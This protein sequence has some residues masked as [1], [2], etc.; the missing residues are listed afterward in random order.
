MI[1]K[2]SY[3]RVAR[4]E[5]YIDYRYTNDVAVKVIPK[6]DITEEIEV[7]MCVDREKK[8]AA[9]MAKEDPYGKL[10]KFLCRTEMVFSDVRNF[11]VVSVSPTS[12]STY[13]L[14][15]GHS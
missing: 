15:I 1:G 2:G 3:G 11:Y 7:H 12:H 4:A 8:V 13:G 5:A 6:K 14:W 10:S 9:R